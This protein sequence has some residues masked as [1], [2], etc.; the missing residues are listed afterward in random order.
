MCC[1]FFSFTDIWNISYKTNNFFKNMEMTHIVGVEG[2]ILFASDWHIAHENWS[3]TPLKQAL[4]KQ[5]SK[6]LSFIFLQSH[7]F[8]I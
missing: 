5:N 1:I 6:I 2:L 4:H 3:L 8:P 7:A